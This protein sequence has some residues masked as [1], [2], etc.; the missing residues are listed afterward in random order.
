MYTL[1]YHRHAGRGK[2]DTFVPGICLIAVKHRSFGPLVKNEMA[3]YLY[4]GNSM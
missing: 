1:D 4:C 2:Y 3:G